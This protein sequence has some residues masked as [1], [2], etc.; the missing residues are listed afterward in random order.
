M[1]SIRECVQTVVLVR[2]FWKS[3]NH[4]EEDDRK[5]ENRKA[6]PITNLVHRKTK[7][8]NQNLQE[9]NIVKIKKHI[10]HRNDKKQ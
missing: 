3:V 8:V 2:T 9:A 4:G 10:R 1:G 6:K 5:G 7:K